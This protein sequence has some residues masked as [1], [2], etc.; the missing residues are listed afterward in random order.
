MTKVV[1]MYCMLSAK[2][3]YFIASQQQN[4][5]WSWGK[6]ASAC[7]VNI[8]LILDRDRYFYLSVSIPFAIRNFKETYRIM[9]HVILA[10]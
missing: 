1:G 8:S 9:S 4:A 5:W 2:A 3:E 10:R 7:S 6:S